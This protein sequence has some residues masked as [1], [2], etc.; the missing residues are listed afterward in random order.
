MMEKTP[1]MVSIPN[2]WNIYFAVSDCDS[3]A[4]K[5]TELGG[6]VIAQPFDTAFGKMAVAQDPQGATF[7]IIQTSQPGE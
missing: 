3:G 4:A 5:I 6:T 2:Y 7:S 1:D